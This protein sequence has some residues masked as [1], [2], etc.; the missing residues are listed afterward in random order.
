MPSM[1]GAPVPQALHPSTDQ[2]LALC[3]FSWWSSRAFPHKPSPFIS[4]DS[5]GWF[6]W[7]CFIHTFRKHFFFLF[8]SSPIDIIRG[9]YGNISGGKGCDVSSKAGVIPGS[10]CVM[11]LFPALLLILEFC[12]L[13][14]MGKEK[15]MPE[16]LPGLIK[17][18]LWKSQFKKGKKFGI[19]R[20]EFSCAMCVVIKV[21]EMEEEWCNK[22]HSVAVNIL[23]IQEDSDSLR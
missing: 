6:P 14:N 10:P 22:L 1:P 23:N 12:T 8:F 19:S 15:K 7:S 11:A 4:S 21:F 13:S 3:R 20:S 5:Q 9:F 18:K 2:G 16:G 17:L